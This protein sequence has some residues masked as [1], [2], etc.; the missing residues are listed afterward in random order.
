MVFL[1]ELCDGETIRTREQS[2]PS[3]R[4]SI[5][6]QKSQDSDSIFHKRTQS[7][8]SDDKPLLSFCPPLPQQCSGHSFFFPS[9]NLPQTAESISFS[10]KPPQLMVHFPFCQGQ[11]VPMERLVFVISD[12]GTWVRAGDSGPR[13]IAQGVV[14]LLVRSSGSLKNLA[15]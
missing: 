4:I 14:D 15:G 12:W 13:I 6:Y 5:A 7:I 9:K 3:D 8:F 2:L 1:S 10:P 11:S